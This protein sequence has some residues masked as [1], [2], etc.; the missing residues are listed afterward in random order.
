[1]EDVMKK[2]FVSIERFILMLNFHLVSLQEIR[3]K[4]ITRMVLILHQFGIVPPVC[5][6]ASMDSEFRI[7]M[8]I[9]NNTYRHF[10]MFFFDK[11]KC[12]TFN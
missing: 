3:L 12:K 2:H 8:T 9:T 11:Y 10:Q 1:M 6:T 4:V 7:S 5:T